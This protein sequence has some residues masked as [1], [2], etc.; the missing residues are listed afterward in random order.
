VSNVK[1]LDINYKTDELF[2]D[3]RNFGNEDLY[4]VDELRGE[5]IDASSDSPFYGIYVGDRLGARMALYRKG[6]VEEVYFSD[7]DDYNVLW[8]LEV[9]RDF[10]GRGYGKALLDFAKEQGQPIKVIA[11]NQSKDF[12]IKQGFKDIELQNKDGHDVLI[13]TP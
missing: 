8:K 11:R 9:L 7:F 4:L 10:Q 5:M 6:E 12:F 2:E 1:R 3:F 13:W